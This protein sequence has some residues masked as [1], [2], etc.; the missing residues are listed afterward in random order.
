MIIAQIKSNQILVIKGE[1][2]GVKHHQTTKARMSAATTTASLSLRLSARE[3]KPRNGTERSFIDGL[4]SA[5]L[6]LQ[7]AE[8]AVHDKALAI[9]D[10]KR[11]LQQAKMRKGLREY[12]A[13]RKRKAVE[14]ANV[15]VRDA[16]G[17]WHAAGAIR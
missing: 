12:N 16:A 7:K 11:T 15:H 17:A 1:A 2:E 6:E 9:A 14:Q 4:V 13:F 10:A 8:N 5:H 3:G